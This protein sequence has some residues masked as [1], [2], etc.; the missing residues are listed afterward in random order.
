[1]KAALLVELNKKL[2]IVELDLPETLAIGQVLVKMIH[3]G[4]CGSQLG[5]ISGVKGEDKYLPHLL[6]HEGTGR[7]IEVGPGVKNVKKGDIVVLHWRKGDGIQSETPVYKWNGRP[8][9]AGWVT[10][11]NEF[12]V[13]SENRLTQIETEKDLKIV[14]LF[15]CALTTGFGV[16]ENNA[17]LKMGE[18]VVVFG[19]GGVGLNIIQA[20][21]LTNAYPIIAVDLYD[22]RLELARIMGATHIINTN[23]L[24]A[25]DEINKIASDDGIDVFVDNTGLPDIISLGY[26]LIKSDGRL[27]LVGVPK[28]GVST[29]FNT[30]PIHFGKKLI[31]SHG[32]NGNP[33]TDIPRY[34]KLFIKGKLKLENII[35][36]NYSLEN[37]NDAVN[38]MRTGVATGRC[39]INF[40]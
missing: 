38:D 14:A 40:N 9:S 34:N 29:S 5:E 31:G 4:I 23:K 12:T 15:G 7:V 10:T 36:N 22:N 11:F 33:S 16:I 1:M 19:A 24:I 6:G 20:A 37:I 26:E 3:S 2:E 39:I 30:L 27:V 17:K 28:A 32:G 8:V 25:K 13:C 21:A 35:T 18:S